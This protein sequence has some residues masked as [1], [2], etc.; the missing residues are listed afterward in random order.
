MRSRPSQGWLPLWCSPPC[1]PRPSGR[2]PPVPAAH[3]HPARPAR[4]RTPMRPERRVR[5][6]A[7]PQGLQA[8][9]LDVRRRLGRR[10][11]PRRELDKAGNFYVD[12]FTGSTDFP[13]TRVRSRP[14]TPAR[15]TCSWSRST[16]G[17][18]TRAP[19]SRRRRSR[20]GSGGTRA[21]GPA[22]PGTRSPGCAERRSSGGRPATVSWS[23]SSGPRCPGRRSG[24][25]AASP[26]TS[27]WRAGIRP[28]APAGRAWRPRPGDR[29]AG[30]PPARP[31]SRTG[32]RRSAPGAG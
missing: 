12:G 4:P 25:M 21:R 29:A 11:R 13:V 20:G 14:R 6:Q 28:V 2:P 7:Q 1:A 15:S 26:L 19:G 24:G 17:G 16:W 18:G 22:S 8:R 23:A 27:G 5:D 31:R 9:L 10:R 30:A 3:S 32:S